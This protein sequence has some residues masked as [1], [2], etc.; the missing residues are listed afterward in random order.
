A[1]AGLGRTIALEFAKRGAKTH[2]L[3]RNPITGESARSEMEN[4]TGNKNIFLHVVDVSRPK[5]IKEFVKKFIS[6]VHA[7][8]LDILVNNAGVLLN[9]RKLTPDNLETTFATNTLGG[10]YLTELLIPTLTKSEDPRVVN[11]SSGG[12]YNTK[13]D[14]SDLQSE[15]LLKWNGPLV[16]AQ[17][18]RAQVELTEYWA[19]K[20]GPKIKF[21]CMHPGWVDTPGVQTSIPEFHSTMEGNLRTQ[22]Q[23]AD[24][25][26]W[27]SI[28][29]EAKSLRNGVFLFDRKEVSPHITGGLTKVKGTT[30]IEQLVKAL[31]EIAERITNETA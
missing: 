6:G 5:E 15:K 12:M 7:E 27:A 22:L 24:T 8:K 23:G 10:Y 2:I 13:F 14:S 17:S 30:I 20:Y 3:C 19:K 28:S 25:I 21:F 26:I 16:Y 1:N 31:D 29:E 11:I 9:E 4:E 18:K